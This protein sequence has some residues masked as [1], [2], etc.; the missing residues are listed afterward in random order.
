MCGICGIIE[1][2]GIVDEGF[3]K[4]MRDTMT[5]R[6]PDD[7]GFYITKNGKVGLGHRRLSIID[8]S[9]AGHQPM[10]N[11]D[12]TIWVTFNGEIYNFLELKEYLEQRGHVF[13]SRC[14][15]EVIVH[16]Y[17]EFG[18]EFPIH[19]DGQFAIGLWDENQRVLFLAR[20]RVGKKPLYYLWDGKRFIFASEIKAIVADPSVP[21]EINLS[22]LDD[23]LT[24][25]YVPYPDTIFKAIKKLPPA[26]FLRFKEGNIAVQPYWKL[27]PENEPLQRDESYYEEQLFSLLRDA[28]KK[29]LISDVPLGVFLSGGVD[30]STIVKMMSEVAGGRIKT[31]SVG[32]DVDEYNELPYANLIARQFDTDHQD[33]VLAPESAVDL[34]PEI[35]RQFDEPLADQ[36]AVPTYL[37][38]KLARQKVTVCLSGEGS[39]ELFGGY[40]RYDL[41]IRQHQLVEQLS[42]HQRELKSA[43]RDAL[44]PSLGAYVQRLCSFNT[45]EKESLL[46]SDVKQV[47]KNGNTLRFPHLQSHYKNTNGFNYLTRLQHLDIHT[48]LTDNL[49][50]KIDRASMLASLEVRAPMLDHKLL[51]FGINLPYNLKMRA[52]IQKY[53]LKKIM[54]PHLPPEIIWRPKMGF[55]IP[56]HKWFKG[57][58]KNYVRD[59]LITGRLRKD[60]Y[61]NNEYIDNLLNDNW[62]DS[63]SKALKV[64]TLII[65]EEWR[66]QYNV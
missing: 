14:D 23:Y 54:I 50:V 12:G 53:I 37:M 9:P 11:E 43:L 30:S 62:L 45:E 10:S 39:D 66:K 41:A 31:F 6:G 19:L 33:I 47:I 42:F 15:T 61:F 63:P 1:T 35:A 26:H 38:S 40:G 48:Y 17:E 34:I 13:R 44:T 52:T 21:R 57:D 56:L 20:D 58:L 7:A 4:R 3:L 46:N 59:L 65:F 18:D 25:Q 55:S 22:A 16:L 29:R 24:F 32:F 64:W 49:L 2:R 28:V 8:L 36:A 51:E 60:G 5:H 27:V